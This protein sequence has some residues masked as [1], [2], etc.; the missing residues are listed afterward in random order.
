M[1]RG[2]GLTCWEEGAIAKLKGPNEVT[3]KFYHILKPPGSRSATNF[4]T[5]YVAE[6]LNRQP[7]IYN[8]DRVLSRRQTLEI[9]YLGR[10]GR[11]IKRGGQKISRGIVKKLV[12][13]VEN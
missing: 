1:R 4:S 5:L 11:K 7:K 2:E 10:D 3:F 12:A 8:L 13:A 9:L 6:M